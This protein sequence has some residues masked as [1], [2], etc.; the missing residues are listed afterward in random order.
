MA[1][2]SS[3]IQSFKSENVR[4]EWIIVY[5]HAGRAINSSGPANT[6]AYNI[7]HSMIC[8]SYFSWWTTQIHYECNEA[9][10]Q[11]NQS[12]NCLTTQNSLCEQAQHFKWDYNVRQLNFIQLQTMF[13]RQKI[14]C[15]LP[16]RTWCYSVASGINDKTRAAHYIENCP[17]ILLDFTP[18]TTT[19]E[20]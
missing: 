8:R 10:N 9:T 1:T 14:H 3:R 17:F 18:T 15:S 13:W 6:Q 4:N 20:Q 2:T 11:I 12:I 16:Q 19:T 7:T 5:A